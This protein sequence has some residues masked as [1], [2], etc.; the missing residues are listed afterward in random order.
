MSALKVL[1]CIVVG[2]VVGYL[3]NRGVRN[4]IDELDVKYEI[5]TMDFNADNKP[6]GFKL[7]MTKHTKSGALKLSKSDEFHINWE[8]EVAY[9]S[10]RGWKDLGVALKEAFEWDQTNGYEFEVKEDIVRMFKVA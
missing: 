5:P 6:I 9:I 4:V 1:G 8:G 3:A 2:G 10:T 7:K